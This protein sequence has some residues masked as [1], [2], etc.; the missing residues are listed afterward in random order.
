MSND[1]LK[2]L[3]ETGET[4]LLQ[5]FIS[6]GKGTQYAATLKLIRDDTGALD[7]KLAFPEHKTGICP[8]C[9]GSL[10]GKNKLYECPCGFKLWK[11]IAGKTLT[12]AQIKTLLEKGITGEIKGFVGK[13]GKPFNAKLMINHEAKKVEFQFNH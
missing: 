5:G 9:S 6:K 3:A 11:T 13:S 1:E 4:D 8:C 12:E 10:N 2:Q 7:M